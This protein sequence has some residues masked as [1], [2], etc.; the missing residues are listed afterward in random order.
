MLSQ[1]VEQSE[2]SIV[3]QN[4]QVLST[5]ASYITELATFVNTSMVD[6]NVTVGLILSLFCIVY[7]ISAPFMIRLS[8]M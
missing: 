4:S 1:V 8:E 3:E 5:V 6:I 7:E 2:D